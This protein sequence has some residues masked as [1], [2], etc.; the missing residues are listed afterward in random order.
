MERRH[1]FMRSGLDL[2]WLQFHH[3]YP[4]GEEASNTIM[5]APA[6]IAM[7]APRPSDVGALLPCPLFP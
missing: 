1:T 2:I 5:Q 7:L 6:T 4:A 3:M